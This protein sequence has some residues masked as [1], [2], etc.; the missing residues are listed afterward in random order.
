MKPN[1]GTILRWSVAILGAIPIAISA[2]EVSGDGAAVLT[3]LEPYRSIEMN[4]AEG[5]VISEILVKEGARVTKGEILLKLDSEAIEARLKVAEAQ[6]KRAKEAVA[7]SVRLEPGY[8]IEWS[9]QYENMIRVRERLK[10][11][12]PITIVLIALLLYANTGSAAK[13]GIVLLAV[14]FS[15]VGAV[16][17]TGRPEGRGRNE[18]ISLMIDSA[19]SGGV[20]APMSS[21]A[22]EW[23]RAVCPAHNPSE[24]TTDSA[25][26]RLATRP[27]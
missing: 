10:L 24:P 5:G 12:L 17:G 9:G 18:T 25:R 16:S 22:G 21:P 4:P 3:Y 23:M 13:A 26:L 8:S 7:A 19:I 14:P 6:V 2:Q 27:M 1:R 20:R 15:V 11:V